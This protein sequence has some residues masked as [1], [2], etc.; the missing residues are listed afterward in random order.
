MSQA[1]YSASLALP[2]AAASSEILVSAFA[3]AFGEIFVFDSL[4]FLSLPSLRLS[5]FIFHSII[6]PKPPSR[7]PLLKYSPSPLS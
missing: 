2:S 5:H 6:C 1:S 7:S 4:R 3:F